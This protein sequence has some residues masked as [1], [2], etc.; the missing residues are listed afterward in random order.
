MRLRRLAGFVV[1]RAIGRAV[2]W[3]REAA[4]RD[5]TYLYAELASRYWQVM[6]DPLCLTRPQYAWGVVQGVSLAQVLQVKR[7]SVIEFG[8]A[9]GSGL[10]ALERLRARWADVEFG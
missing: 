9:G 1:R 3:F 8:V 10:V 5:R 6:S 7:T 4:V 2:D